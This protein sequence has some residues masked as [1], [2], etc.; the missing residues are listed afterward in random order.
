MIGYGRQ[1]IE[2]SD[3]D[4]LTKV[5]TADFLT[6]GPV[7]EQFEHAIAEYVGAKYAVTFTSATA[8]LHIACLAAGLGK[9][10][11]GVTQPITFVASANC[12]A[13]CQAT[14]HLVDIDPITLNMSKEKLKLFLSQQPEC[15]VVIPV[16]YSGYSALD[17][18]FC[19]IV[20][21][22]IIIEDS[23]HSLGAYGTDGKK[24]GSGA[25]ADMTVFSFHPVKPITTGEG[26]AVV[27]NNN[28]LYEKMKA[29]R[30]HGIVRDDFQLQASE[31]KR[32][33]W[34]Y[35]QQDLGYNYRLTD[36]Q[37]ALGISQLSRIDDFMSKRRAVAARY[38]EAFANLKHITLR[39]F[40]PEWRAKSG[41]HLYI[42]HFDFKGLGKSRGDVMAEL[43]SK[44]IGT[45]VHYVPVY[46]HPYHQ[47]DA[48]GDVSHYP[49]SEAYYQGC[50]SIPIFPSLT[51]EQQ[52]CVI[53]AIKAL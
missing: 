18:E 26:G 24:V 22:R 12:I 13:Y 3:I 5:L 52:H 6:Q 9:G 15:K 51:V 39:Q 53:S 31:N 11:I 16:S 28:D 20:G 38:D 42:L 34:Y 33:P 32:G 27:T 29:L 30:S 48:I 40:D 50:L 44:G 17:E 1:T 45:Q 4:A 47:T 46:A 43:R 36:I 10:N 8:G 41:H 25:F 21:E 2:Q 23:S 37:S 35:E 14:P 49:E 7:V 19:D